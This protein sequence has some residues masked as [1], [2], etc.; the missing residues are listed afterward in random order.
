MRPPIDVLEYFSNQNTDIL[1]EY[2][3]PFGQF[4]FF[5]D[6]LR[7]IVKEYDINLVSATLRYVRKNTEAFL[8]YSDHDAIAIVLYINQG[9]SDQ[10]IEKARLWTQRLIDLALQCHGQYYLTYQSYG[11]RAQIRQ[12]YPRIDE[13]FERKRTHDPEEFFVNSFYEKYK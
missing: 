5:I 4:I 3:V 6:G 13:F 10:G 7:E 1:Q 9:L 8:S 11:T 2:F 12:V